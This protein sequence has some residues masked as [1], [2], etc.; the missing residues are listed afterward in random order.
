MIKDIERKYIQK[1]LEETFN[2]K[3][4]LTQPK[5]IKKDISLLWKVTI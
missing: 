4:S 1:S 3:D 2:N 5:E